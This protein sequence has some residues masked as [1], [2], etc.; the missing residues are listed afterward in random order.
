MACLEEVAY[1]NGSMNAAKLQAS[2]RGL[3]KTSCAEY[4]QALFESGA[5]PPRSQVKL[6][7]QVIYLPFFTF[8]ILSRTRMTALLTK[9]ERLFP[10]FFLVTHAHHPP[11]FRGSFSAHRR[12]H[13]NLA[14]LRSDARGA[15]RFRL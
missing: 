10:I 9:S 15:H 6:K 13:S 11:A 7:E 5:T 8:I 14:V 12:G 4:L 1:H 2:I 3:S